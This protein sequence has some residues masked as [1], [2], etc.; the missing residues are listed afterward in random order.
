MITTVGAVGGGSCQLA[1]LALEIGCSAIWALA[2]TGMS[3]VVRKS[4]SAAIHA[5]SV[6]GGCLASRTRFNTVVSSMIGVFPRI[7]GRTGLLAV[8]GLS[9]RALFDALGI[10]ANKLVLRHTRNTVFSFGFV[11]ARALADAGVRGVIS[12][13]ASFAGA[14]GAFVVRSLASRAL[15]DA[16]LCGLISVFPSIRTRNALEGI[17][18]HMTTGANAQVSFVECQHPQ[19]RAVSFDVGCL[20]SRALTRALVGGMVCVLPVLTGGASLVTVRCL[21]SRT[22]IDTLVGSL[23]SVFALRTPHAAPHTRD[24]PCRT[25]LDAVVVSMVSELIRGTPRARSVAFARDLTTR[26]L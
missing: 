21:A 11:S 9:S 15:V 7:T 16:I 22:L 10:T 6:P 2:N 18:G 23:V 4:A 20:A 26:A 3:K 12:V 19:T 17:V 14:A 25:F 24:G 5:I 13:L 1:I 8:G